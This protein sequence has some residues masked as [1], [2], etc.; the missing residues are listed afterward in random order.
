MGDMASRILIVDD[1]EFLL[2]MYAVKFKEEG[3]EVDAAENADAAIEKLKSKTY[4]MVLFDMIM[5]GVDGLEFLKKASALKLEEKPVFVALSNQSQEGD[6]AKAKELG[7]T[8]YI[9]KATAVPSEV[10]G[11]VKAHLKS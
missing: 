2:D 10:V 7:A 1:D 3:F 9:I 4:A 6:I 5:P 11:R 8:D